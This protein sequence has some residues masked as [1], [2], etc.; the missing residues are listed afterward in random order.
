MDT[1][2]LVTYGKGNFFDKSKFKPVKNA[3]YWNKPSGGLWASP[4]NAQY[5]WRVWCIIEKFGDLTTSFEFFITG[6]IFKIENINDLIQL[7]LIVNDDIYYKSLSF[8][9]TFIDFEA[10]ANSGIDAIWLTED[11]IQHKEFYGWDCE[12]VLILNSNCIE[13]SNM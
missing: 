11:A 12:S 2:S 7:P 1:L 8:Y 9:N 13:T 5:G 6:N 3:P 4:I 10:V